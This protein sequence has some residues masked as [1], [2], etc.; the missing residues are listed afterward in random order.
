MPTSR[1]SKTVAKRSVQFCTQC[2]DSLEGFWQEPEAEDFKGL[3][4]RMA[5]CK[6]EGKFQGNYCSRLWIAGG[7]TPKPTSAQKRV[8]KSTMT[9]LKAGIEKKLAAERRRSVAP[10]R[11]RAAR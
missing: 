8:P 6:A 1:K 10:P 2:G 4:Q 5:R 3:L 11:R 9:R 7:E